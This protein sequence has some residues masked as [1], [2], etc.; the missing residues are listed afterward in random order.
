MNTSVISIYLQLL[1]HEYQARHEAGYRAALKTL[2]ETS[3]AGLHAIHDER[4]IEAGAPDF[5]LTRASM[6][7][8]YVHTTD[9]AADLNVAEVEPQIALFRV[10]LPNF[11]LTN[12]LEF[13]WY[14]FGQLHKSGRMAELRGG[15]L[16]RDRSAEHTATLLSEFAHAA[17]SSI[18]HPDD[19]AVRL[20]YMTHLLRNLI[21]NIL[22]APNRDLADPIQA[23]YEMMRLD[24]T[25][26]DFADL[27]AQTLVYGLLAARIRHRGQGRQQPFT[28]RDAFWDLPATMPLLKTLFYQI[29]GRNMDD[30][31]AWIA[32]NL[33]DV[34][35][36]VD[37]DAVLSSFR[38]V[39]RQEDPINHF[40]EVFLQHYTP[41]RRAEP[42]TPE[43]IVNFM[44]RAV[45]HLLRKRFKRALGLADEKTFIF[46]PA[47][48]T[49]TF[50]YFI[51]QQIYD[52]LRQQHQ[53]GAWDVYVRDS[54]LERLHGFESD[55]A[56]Y[57][58]AHLKLAIQL[59]AL[60]YSFANNQRLNLYL[61][62][63][64]TPPDRSD[65]S[66]A[67]AVVDEAQQAAQIQKNAWINVEI[68]S[69]PA[70]L[71][72]FGQQRITAS[73]SGILAYILD[74][75]ALSSPT[76]ANMRRQLAATFDHIYIIHSP[77]E[78][79]AVT[80]FV[81]RPGGHPHRFRYVEVEGDLSAWLAKHD[82]TNI[83]W[84]E[85][86]PHAPDYR[87]VP[88]T[89]DL[90]AEYERGWMLTDIFP[91]TGCSRDDRLCLLANESFC[92]LVNSPLLPNTLHDLGRAFPLYNRKSEVVFAPGRNDGQINLSQVFILAITQRL[93]MTFVPD[94]HGNLRST[95]GPEDV[96]AYA[97][98]VLSSVAYRERYAAFLEVPRL[99]LTSNRKLFRAL[100]RRGRQLIDY[101][102]MQRVESWRLVTGYAGP[103]T[104]YTVA[105]DS[106]RFVD[107]AGER[108]GRVYINHDKYVQNVEREIWNFQVGGVSVLRQWIEDRRGQP[109][110]WSDL[111]HFQ[112]MIV[113]LVKTQRTLRQIDE[114]VPAWPLL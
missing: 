35:A 5:I 73:G 75:E 53:L 80:L 77:G 95:F 89:A 103:G 97:Y 91:T 31:L 18:N 39:R 37:T 1:Q 19:L 85:L 30:R 57:T 25:P 49:G 32:D 8:G 42:T 98:A 4:L 111:L 14:I 13:R 76:Y 2:L 54:L 55:I 99:P 107:L 66:F 47:A 21:V 79:R 43:P 11:I 22:I 67:Q 109:L 44:V 26:Q 105:E 100:V 46:D 52:T 96:F 62:S 81:R 38:Q 69:L 102:L 82:L 23:Y 110:A 72:P 60:G 7:V 92:W 94:G 63:K 61:I 88:Q 15:T 48:G 20:A 29:E 33:T 45:D 90:V 58:V 50:L 112:T 70:D 86:Q 24:T 78:N 51:I 114:L 16:Q 108:G 68:G 9:F 17:V 113:S 104:D 36:R 87:L 64:I 10:A 83:H 74:A 28:R 40:Y 6:Q 59:D 12:Y 34:L 106:P 56:H 3:D 84:Q 65:N 93:G 71:L 101:H 41:E 27:Y